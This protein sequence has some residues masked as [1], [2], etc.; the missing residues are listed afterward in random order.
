MDQVNT[1]RSTYDVH[2]IAKVLDIDTTPPDLTARESRIIMDF[3]FH[4][5]RAVT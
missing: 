5:H 3:D 2:D 4:T 1:L